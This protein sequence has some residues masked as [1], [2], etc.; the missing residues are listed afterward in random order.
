[1]RRTRPA[2][3]ANDG[4]IA[5]WA[6]TQALLIHSVSDRTATCTY[7]PAVGRFLTFAESR[8]PVVNTYAELDRA[9]VEWM[10][11]MCYSQQMQ[12][13]AGAALLNG[14][15]YI[16]PELAA[17][18]PC[19]WRA[20]KAWSKVNLAQEGA[21]IPDESIAVMAK[22]LR[23]RGLPNDEDA[24]DAMLL[25]TDA[26]L[27]EQD[28]V[29][30]RCVDVHL[31]H[32]AQGEFAILRLGV[33]QRGEATKCGHDEGVSVDF[34]HNIKMLQRRLAV[35][36]PDESLFG[37]DDVTYRQKWHEA[38]SLA[39]VSVGP[40]HSA[41]HAGASR[42]LATAYRQQDA[43]MRRGRWRSEVSVRR[44]G[45]THVW[46][47]LRDSQPTHVISEGSVI[48]KDWERPQI[49]RL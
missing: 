2:G 19:A 13:M 10:S 47:A 11:F 8:R 33:S 42:D 22:R 43:V 4:D 28:V 23:E 3:A 34:M 44:Y 39:G 16:M 46:F 48:I 20:L 18:M 25:A 45:K 29:R 49:P 40:P 37:L 5:T 38:A 14:L 17:K 41:R 32:D 31:T 9:L 7:L 27:R 21:P 30:L 6:G 15:V 1:M 36:R 26:Y 12:Q 24:A 35:R